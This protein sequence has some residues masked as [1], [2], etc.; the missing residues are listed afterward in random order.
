M[1]HY[2]R[3]HSDGLKL[4]AALEQV[5]QAHDTEAQAAIIG[6]GYVGME[7]AAALV[8]RGIKV[9]VHDT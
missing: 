9:G 7:V 5:E 1:T 4:I 3:D 8:N 2:L 6:G